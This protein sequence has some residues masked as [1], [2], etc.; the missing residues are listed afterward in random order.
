MDPDVSESE[1]ESESESEGSQDLSQEEIIEELR[2]DIDKKDSEIY[3]LKMIKKRLET[4]VE[5][6]KQRVANLT[7]E[8]PSQG[9]TQKNKH[10]PYVSKHSTT[11]KRNASRRHS[12][13]RK[14]SGTLRRMFRK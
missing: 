5:V 8:L 6:L 11:S 9:G 14:K 10:L 3:V 12:F 1:R 2:F 4:Q 13:Q 7:R